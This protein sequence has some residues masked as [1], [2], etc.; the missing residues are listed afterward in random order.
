M[1]ALIFRHHILAVGEYTLC[2]MYVPLVKTLPFYS[3]SVSTTLHFLTFGQFCSSALRGFKSVCNFRHLNHDMR[4]LCRDNLCVG[5][6]QRT[7]AKQLQ[8]ALFPPKNL[9]NIHLLH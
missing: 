7:H 1:S 4:S 8:M 2:C 3:S 6:N 5:K 9:V